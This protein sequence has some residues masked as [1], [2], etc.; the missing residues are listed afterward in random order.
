MRIDGG[1]IESGSPISA[2]RDSTGPEEAGNGEPVANLRVFDCM[3]MSMD[4]IF[5]QSCEE[6]A[7]FSRSRLFPSCPS[8]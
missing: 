2:L 8:K 7:E 1:N 5:S 3:E 6:I 4:E